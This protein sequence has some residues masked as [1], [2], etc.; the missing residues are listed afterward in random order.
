MYICRSTAGLIFHVTF[1]S[2]ETE[3]P[4][5]KVQVP[6]PVERRPRAGKYTGCSRELPGSRNSQ[7][8]DMQQEA[9]SL[10]QQVGSQRPQAHISMMT[11]YQDKFRPPKS[12]KA[13][14]S[15]SQQN[16]PYHPLKGMAAD[17]IPLRS[18]Y[19]THTRTKSPPPVKAPS[20]PQKNYRRCNSFSHKPTE[21]AAP[22]TSPLVDY[23][24]VYQNDFRVWKEHRC[25]PYTV[26]DCLK[27]HQGLLPPGTTQT[28]KKYVEANPKLFAKEEKPKPM[29]GLTSYR[30]NYV[31][32]PVQPRPRRM[33][34]THNTSR[35]LPLEPMSLRPKIAWDMK[36]THLDEASE[37]FEKFH[38]WSLE[39]KFHC[40]AKECS[41]PFDHKI[42]S[43][44]HSNCLAHKCQ[45]TKPFLPSMQTGEK[46]KEPPQVPTSTKTDCGVRGEPQ[47]DQDWPMKTTFSV[48]KPKYAQNY[49]TTPNTSSPLPRMN[50]SW[51][52]TEKPP[53]P[54]ECRGSSGFRRSTGNEE[55]RVCWF[56]SLDKVTWPKGDTSLAP[57]HTHHR[58]SCMVS[59]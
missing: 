19:V 1:S 58:V 48:C 50:N 21:F 20:V 9:T 24:T 59:S 27:V 5:G 53:C 6:R 55:S 41:P 16:D 40:Q 23:T 56:S 2:F 42:A 3:E 45:G 32:H 12:Y 35:V 28:E 18:A 57:S 13:I 52:G 10:R 7:P 33:K 43:T 51:N 38:S 36:K 22:P 49:K 54:A 15:S 34:P 11:E 8:T 14:I 17:V 31:P 30:L 44:I 47:K 37:F 39:T 26:K 4:A 25:Q 29:E 46:N